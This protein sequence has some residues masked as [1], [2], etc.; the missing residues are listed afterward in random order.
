[1]P[2]KRITHTQ[3][4]HKKIP[5][6]S[7]A[8]RIDQKRRTKKTAHETIDKLLVG[9]KTASGSPTNKWMNVNTSDLRLLFLAFVFFYELQSQE[10]KSNKIRQTNS[11]IFPLT[12]NKQN[13]IQNLVSK[14][15][16]KCKK[17]V[18][19]IHSELKNKI[20]LENSTDQHLQN[21]IEQL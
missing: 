7:P 17:T 13:P 18:I 2:I 11:S 1:M 8:V 10:K 21:S 16:E 3:K 12:I 19:N 14:Y 6:T 4:E 9:K 15:L 20:K 5:F